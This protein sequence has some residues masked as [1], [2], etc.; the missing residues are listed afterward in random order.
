MHYALPRSIM[1]YVL[2]I[3]SH[4]L[5]CTY[6]YVKCSQKNRGISG[7][8]S[9]KKRAPAKD[10]YVSRLLV[11][12]VFWQFPI[13]NGYYLEITDWVPSFLNDEGR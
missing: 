11:E 9:P 8:N 12:I 6:S 13:F 1:H 3:M 10:T 7:G 2:S 4:V 5:Q